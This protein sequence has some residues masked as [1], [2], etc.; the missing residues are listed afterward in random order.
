MPALALQE[1]VIPLRLCPDTD[2]DDVRANSDTL[3][4]TIHS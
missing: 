2:F 3:V 4:A 1:P